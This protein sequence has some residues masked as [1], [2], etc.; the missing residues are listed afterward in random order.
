LKV[1]YQVW[2]WDGTNFKN[3]NNGTPAAGDEPIAETYVEIIPDVA[4]R[5]P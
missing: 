5:C 2:N 1:G 4:L 3:K